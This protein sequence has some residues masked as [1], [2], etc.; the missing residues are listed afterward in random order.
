MNYYESLQQ[1]YKN[2]CVLHPGQDPVWGE[3]GYE[4][5]M[6]S[7]ISDMKIK[8]GDVIRVEQKW[9]SGKT[10]NYEGIVLQMYEDRFWL[11]TQGKKIW[12]DRSNVKDVIILYITKIE[13]IKDAAPDF[14]I[15]KADPNYKERLSPGDR[16]NIW[17]KIEMER[18][19][20]FQ[21]EILEVFPLINH[22]RNVLLYMLFDFCW[23]YSDGEVQK[24]EIN[25]IKKNGEQIPLPE[26]KNKHIYPNHDYHSCC[27]IENTDK[28]HDGIVL[29]F[30][31]LEALQ[32]IRFI[33][34]VWTVEWDGN[35]TR[36]LQ[37][38]Y[39]NFTK[40][41]GNI[42]NISCRVTD[43]GMYERSLHSHSVFTGALEKEYDKAFLYVSEAEDEGTMDIM[44]AENIEDDE[45]MDAIISICK[46]DLTKVMESFSSREQEV[47]EVFIK[48][49]E[50]EPK[51]YIWPY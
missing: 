31:S 37:L 17:E 22:E 24:A 19:E 29:F 9:N 4:E 20:K 46:N 43:M 7:Q 32:E 50:V 39:P 14:D 13:K 26:Y 36:F 2:G 28:N 48:K 21:K 3:V 30:V 8:S 33:S 18:T 35:N 10:E 25:I 1:Y 38:V 11:L 45:K 47:A 42:Y 41:D 49:A 34:C 27:G 16:E 5:F 6:K 51:G 40:G 23:T 12:K 44:N 15:Q